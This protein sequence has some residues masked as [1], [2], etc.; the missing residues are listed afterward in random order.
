MNEL[1]FELFG[2]ASAP[3]AVPAT[4][5]EHPRLKEVR[6]SMGDTKTCPDTGIEYTNVTIQ[7][8]TRKVA[9]KPSK[10]LKSPMLFNPATPVF[11]AQL[12]TYDS[13][14]YASRLQRFADD[15]KTLKPG[16]CYENPVGNIDTY[17]GQSAEDKSLYQDLRGVR[18]YH[19][20]KQF[21]KRYD[22]AVS[23]KYR[24]LSFTLKDEVK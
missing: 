11:T 3:A 4:R 24:K 2:K 14:Q 8:E 19:Y 5:A 22:V 20:G 9:T 13:E 6:A 18:F 1:Q 7:G 21:L 23:A 12:R 17:I 15:L 16:Q 10:H